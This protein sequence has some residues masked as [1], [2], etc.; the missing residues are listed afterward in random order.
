MERLIVIVDFCLRKHLKLIK[1][2]Q[3]NLFKKE[4]IGHKDFNLLEKPSGGNL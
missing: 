3:F 4:N 2:F 1:I